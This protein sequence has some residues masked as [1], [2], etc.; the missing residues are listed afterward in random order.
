MGKIL[1]R[2]HRSYLNKLNNLKKSINDS[3]DIIH[4]AEYKILKVSMHHIISYCKSHPTCDNC[5]FRQKHVGCLFR[6]K[7]PREW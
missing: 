3:E 7:T 1:D 6:D 4:W 5:I 2:L